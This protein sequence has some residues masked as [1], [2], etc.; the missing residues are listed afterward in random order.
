M[1]PMDCQEAFDLSER[2]QYR[3]DLDAPYSGE[4]YFDPF[5]RLE[6]QVLLME[7]QEPFLMLTVPFLN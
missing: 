4:Y 1:D 5:S 2:P 6:L 7:L 3:D